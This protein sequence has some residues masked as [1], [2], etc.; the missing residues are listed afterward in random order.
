MAT[1]TTALSIKERNWAEWLTLQVM[2]VICSSHTGHDNDKRIATISHD[3]G[4]NWGP[5]TQEQC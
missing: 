4:I 1:S 2:F 5:I 3:F